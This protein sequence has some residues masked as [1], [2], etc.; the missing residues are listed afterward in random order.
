MDPYSYFYYRYVVLGLIIS[1]V[2]F[3]VQLIREMFR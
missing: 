2:L 3:V 1:A